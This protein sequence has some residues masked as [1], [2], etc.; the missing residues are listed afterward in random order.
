MYPGHNNVSL[1][2]NQKWKFKC[3]FDIQIETFFSNFVCWEELYCVLGDIFVAWVNFFVPWVSW[4]DYNFH[5]ISIQNYIK[6]FA[7]VSSS[8]NRTK[9]F[10][11]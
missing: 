10:Y 5:G 1:S 9:Y 3:C 8:E 7:S 4:E 11:I 2:L 6:D